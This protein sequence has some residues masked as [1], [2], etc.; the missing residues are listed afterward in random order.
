MKITT[1]I[2]AL[3]L[4]TASTGSCNW[5][6][7]NALHKACN[8]KDVTSHSRG[9]CVGLIASAAASASN[10]PFRKFTSQGEVDYAIKLEAFK[11]SETY[12]IA[13]PKKQKIE[14]I[15]EIVKKF[16]ND[17]PKFLDED[18]NYIVMLALREEFGFNKEKNRF[19]NEIM[20]A[21]TGD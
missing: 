18:A 17:Y 16:M 2:L 21:L 9:V 3:A 11:N 15:I 19:Y 7:G 6:D 4:C 13:V 8:N 20:N 1:L 10:K 14:Q 12:Y 5:F